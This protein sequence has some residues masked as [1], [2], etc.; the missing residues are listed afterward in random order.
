MESGD[1]KKLIE[2]GL[3]GVLAQIDGADGTHF[4]AVIIGDVFDGLSPLK[5]HQA[6]YRAL[7]DK[8]GREIHALSMQIY[9]SAEWE[10]VQRG[11]KE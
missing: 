8:M 6:V 2:S 4:Q 3:P 1:I 7:G 9:T 10:Q 5:R 11:S